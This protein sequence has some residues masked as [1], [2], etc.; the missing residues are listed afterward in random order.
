MASA[1]HF[2]NNSPR[3]KIMEIEHHER[4]EYNLEMAENIGQIKA[5]LE[6]L[7]GDH[8]R[9]TALE[10]AQ[11]TADTRFW[12]QTAVIVPLISAFHITAKKLGF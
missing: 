5:M 12:V 2:T 6:G 8:G 10:K 9:V 1:V 4:R 3:K 11:D 7:A